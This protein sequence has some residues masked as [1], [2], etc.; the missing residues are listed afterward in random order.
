M[1]KK[2]CKADIDTEFLVESVPLDKGLVDGHQQLDRD[3]LAALLAHVANAANIFTAAFKRPGLSSPLS[4]LPNGPISL[5]NLVLR[6][7]F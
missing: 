5:G 3:E 4:L 2:R 6:R 7:L 1:S